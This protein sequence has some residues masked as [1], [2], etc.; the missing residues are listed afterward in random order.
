MTFQG[1]SAFGMAQQIGN[2]NVLVTERT[3]KSM[4]RPEVEKL[5]FELD[6]LQREVRS[7]QPGLTDTVAIQDRQRRLTRLRNCLIMLR[8]YLTGGR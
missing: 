3:F 4:S 8:F 1:G 7:E 2:G 5:R 6:K